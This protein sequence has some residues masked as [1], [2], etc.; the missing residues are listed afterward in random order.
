M[1]ANESAE[2]QGDATLSLT[3]SDNEEQ[4]DATI[5]VNIVKHKEISYTET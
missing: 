3:C 1:R 4:G 2:E 5:P